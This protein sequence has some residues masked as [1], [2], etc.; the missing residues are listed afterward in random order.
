MKRFIG[1]L[2]KYFDLQELTPIIPNDMVKRVYVHA[3]DRINDK[4]TQQIDIYYEG[5]CQCRYFKTKSRIGRITRLY[6][7]KILLFY[8]APPLGRLL[9]LR[10]ILREILRAPP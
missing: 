5:F 1:K 3:P 6:P 4:R 8:L 2:H 7:T 10:F 9:L